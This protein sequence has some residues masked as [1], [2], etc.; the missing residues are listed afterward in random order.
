MDQL[1]NIVYALPA[2]FVA[3]TIHEY[4]HARVADALGDPTPRMMGRITLDPL[5]HID[6][7]GLV[8]LLFAGF[9]WAKPVQINP[10]RFRNIRRD[11]V[12]VAIAGPLANLFL[13]ILSG[14]VYVIIVRFSLRL[15]TAGAVAMKLI[16]PFITWNS[17]LFAFNVL[18]VPPLD[19]YKVLQGWSR[20]PN[21]GFFRFMDKYSRFVLIALVFSGVTS[22]FVSVISS[23][24]QLP[25][26]TLAQFIL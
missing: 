19:G 4:A 6:W 10:S 26:M 7:I 9:G 21:S 1:L 5:A 11:S 16:G 18:P 14:L 3:F 17:M 12:L 24:V 2:V 8:L 13:A 23:I 15:G 22:W 20:H 25:M